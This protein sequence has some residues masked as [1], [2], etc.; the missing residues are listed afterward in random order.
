MQIGGGSVRIELLGSL[1]LIVDR[2]FE[3]A[4]AMTEAARVISRFRTHKTAALLAYHRD[5]PPHAR[6]TLIDTFW[7]ESDAGHRSLRQALSS[8]RSQLKPPGVPAGTV[9][10]TDRPAARLNPVAVTT[11]VAEFEAAIAAAIKA[12]GTGGATSCPSVKRPWG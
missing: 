7:P 2:P 1:R 4:G 6:S 10:V 12:A 9:L 3:G 5:Q 8:L 11:D